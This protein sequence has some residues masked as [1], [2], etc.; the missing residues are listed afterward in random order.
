M[1]IL[2]GNLN[3]H[4]GGRKMNEDETNVIEA[5]SK[6]HGVQYPSNAYISLYGVEL[7]DFMND[8][9]ASNPEL[10]IKYM[11][12][13]NDLGYWVLVDQLK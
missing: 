6:G 1:L 13:D 4:Y 9:K 12:D 8:I 3:N 11:R 7:L 10:N 5:L 2:E